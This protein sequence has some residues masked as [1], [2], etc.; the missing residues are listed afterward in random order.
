MADSEVEE[1]VKRLVK[2]RKDSIAQYTAGHRPDLAEK[3]T[4]ELGILESYLP[5]EMSDEALRDL[6]IETLSEAGITAQDKMGLAMGLVMKKVAG[7]A[8]G[9]RVRALVEKRLSA[10]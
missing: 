7:R 4:R 10:S 1:V 9:D 3:E 5:A 6:V 8:S 2:Q